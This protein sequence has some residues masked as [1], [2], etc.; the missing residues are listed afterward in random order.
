MIG[1]VATLVLIVLFVVGLAAVAMLV[2]YFGV[3]L[4]ALFVPAAIIAMLVGTGTLIWYEISSGSPEPRD[5]VAI[6]VLWL[7]VGV[8]YRRL[9]L[10][11]KF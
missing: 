2:A 6:A 3:A 11:K 10:W 1:D 9:R 8:A 4:G 7:I 5:A